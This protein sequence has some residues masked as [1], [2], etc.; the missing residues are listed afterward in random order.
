VNPFAAATAPHILKYPSHG[1]QKVVIDSQRGIGDISS[2][3][4]KNAGFWR[5]HK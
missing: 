5:V 3:D 1:R 4:I 2:R